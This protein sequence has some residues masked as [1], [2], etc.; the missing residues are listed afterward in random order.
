MG[1]LTVWT[2]GHST[3]SL[4]EFTALLDENGVREVV[5]VRTMPRSRHTPQFNEDTFGPA[6]DDR[7][8]AYRHLGAL[9]GLRHTTKD[10][11]NTAPKPADSI[12]SR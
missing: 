1:D 4:D 10:S 6:L 2:I 5:D 9:G 8:F 7:G 3:R 11:I 12:I